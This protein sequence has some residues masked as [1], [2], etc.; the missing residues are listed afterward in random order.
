MKP[1]LNAKH[2]TGALELG[3]LSTVL[4]C[5]LPGPTAPLWF[6]NA[7]LSL[8]KALIPQ[9]LILAPTATQEGHL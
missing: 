4:G 5:G 2:P 8:I 1:R 9:T 3:V 7:G 6:H